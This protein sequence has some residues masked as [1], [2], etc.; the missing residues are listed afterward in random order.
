MIHLQEIKVENPKDD[1]RNIITR[2]EMSSLRNDNYNRG[3]RISVQFFK[4]MNKYG[5]YMKNNNFLMIDTIL[6]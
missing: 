3:V 5:I 1:R 6:L 4:K 2:R